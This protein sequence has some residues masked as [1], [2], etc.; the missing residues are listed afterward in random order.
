MSVFETKKKSS[1]VLI[2][3]DRL[4]TVLV[5]DRVNC[6]PDA[7]EKF[8]LELFKT[9][10]KYI[11]IIPENFDVQITRDNIYIKLTGENS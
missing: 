11:D 3:K 7:I 2:A 6:T 4:K 9:V 5:S 8:E 10:S 1:S